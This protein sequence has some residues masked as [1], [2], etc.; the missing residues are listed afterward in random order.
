[1][2]AAV[3]NRKYTTEPDSLC[4]AISVEDFTLTRTCKNEP[5]TYS[6]ELQRDAGDP[7]LP[8]VWRASD[9]VLL[10]PTFTG[11]RQLL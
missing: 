3:P 9:A 10:L 11:Y 8:A 1:M 6:I 5:A 4:E 2:A 7:H